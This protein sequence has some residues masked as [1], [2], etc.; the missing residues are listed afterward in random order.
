MHRTNGL[1]VAGTVL[2][3]IGTIL[4]VVALIATITAVSSQGGLCSIPELIQLSCH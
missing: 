2:G 1:A 3:A 4:L